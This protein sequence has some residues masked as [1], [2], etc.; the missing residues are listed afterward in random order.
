MY[1]DGVFR[2]LHVR[3]GEPLWWSAHLDKLAR[4]AGRLSIPMPATADWEQDLA[5][6]LASTPPDC[7]LKLVL[8]RGPATRGYRPTGQSL[9]TRLM[10]ASAW[11]AHIE[12]VATRG[13]H[14]HLCRLRLSEQPRLAGI[15]HLNRLENVLAAME[16]SDPALDEGLLLDGSGRVICGVSSN[17][18]IY[19]NGALSTPRLDRCGV[20][21][22][23][24]ARLIEVARRL[25]LEVHETDIQL[26]DFLQADEV[27]LT[28]SLIK[29]WRVA[30]LGE[31]TWDAPRVSGEL[32]T[33]L[34]A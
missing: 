12:A 6:L 16:W 29:L 25:K 17:L 32:R 5:T 34:D 11:P 13:A 7:V 24:R 1:G 23:A 18:F 27:M 9:P 14:L 31:R 28:N 33:L 22:V 26:D 21:G 30:R 4:D 8:T 15:K 10:I 3:A 19:R 20:E 2:T